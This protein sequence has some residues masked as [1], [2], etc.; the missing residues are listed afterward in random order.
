MSPHHG[1]YLD[2]FFEINIYSVLYL[3]AERLIGKHSV[4][5]EGWGTMYNIHARKG[6][7]T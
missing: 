4:P 5:S 3:I 6:N 7:H 1:L 2:F